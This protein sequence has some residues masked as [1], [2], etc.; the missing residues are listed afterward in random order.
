MASVSTAPSAGDDA[1]LPIPNLALPQ[2]AFVLTEAKAQHKREGAQERLLKGIEDDEMAPYLSH[3]ASTSV[4]PPQSD[5]LLRLQQR[6]KDEL[7]RLDAKLEDAKTNLGETEISDVLR[8]RATYLARIGEKDEAVKAHEEAFEKS[9]GKGTKIDLVLSI[10]RIGFF[11]SD[12]ELV[13]SNIDRAQKL[14]DEGGDWDRRNRLKVYEG[15]HLLSIRNF[16]KGADLLL[17]ALPTFTA[18]ELLEYDD[19]VV[20]C[21]LAGVLALERKDLKK[22]VIDAPEVIAVVPNVPTIKNFAES[23]YKSD[24][25]TFF[26]CLATA[27]EHH[28]LP[29]RLLSVHSRYYTRELRVKAYA[30]LLESYRSVTLESLCSAFGVSKEWLDND[31]ARFISSGR[32]TC[33]IDRVNGVVETHRPDA[34]NARY[35]AV[36]KQGDAVLTSVQRLSRVIG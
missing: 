24:Y 35:N 15:V 36:I 10:I 8:E 2:L 7:A 31:L 4:L 11:H 34:K 6:N 5:L 26:R 25:A 33:T 18:I 14:V 3:L 21:V 9:A 29:S 13:M 17:D 27:E 19:F 1:P 12:H 32:L 30:Q 22:K 20:L 28:F 16:K 23:L